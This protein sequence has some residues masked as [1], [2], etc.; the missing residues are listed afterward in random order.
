MLT[1]NF[2][3]SFHFPT[4]KNN[5]LDMLKL[6]TFKTFFKNVVPYFV[7]A[8]IGEGETVRGNINQS[9]FFGS[10]GS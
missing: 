8:C 10:F 7:C 9:I 6:C 1:A 3:D 5:V 4:L 2:L